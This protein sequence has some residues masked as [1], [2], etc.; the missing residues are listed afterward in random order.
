LK[1]TYIS[2]RQIYL[3][4]NEKIDIVS[5][6]QISNYLVD[7]GIGRP[8]S[9]LPDPDNANA[10]ILNFTRVFE[11][12]KSYIL[13]LANIKDRFGNQMPSQNIDL[14]YY[15]PQENDV[16][17]TEIFPDP[18]PSVGLPDAEFIEI[19]NHSKFSI[20]LN[21]WRIADPSVTSYLP[22]VLI[23]P[24]SFIILCA[25]SNESKF[26]SYGHA[27][28][29][30]PFPSLNNDRDSIILKDD[31]DKLIQLINYNASWYNDANKKDGGWTLEML[32]PFSLC[33][34]GDNWQASRATQGGTPGKFNSNFK[35]I[36]D[37]SRPY[38]KSL[39]P[40]DS[41][42]LLVV[43]D[44]KMDEVSL[45]QSSVKLDGVSMLSKQK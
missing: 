1:A 2:D 25:L 19:Y 10:I 44:T 5:S 30:S 20:S 18:T 9:V 39:E 7:K 32:N 43:F 36:A 23:K 33:L 34:D 40:I 28:G 4:F 21:N 41:L 16:L 14:L 45:Q 27:I 37:T 22:D 3:L 42:N 15:V 26:S 17:I 13:S 6:T 12:G 38:I 8:L 24:D 31:N 35:N 29:L 11:N